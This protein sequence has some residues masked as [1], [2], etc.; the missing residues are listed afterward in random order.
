MERQDANAQAY[1]S[2]VT[3]KMLLS[4]DI[5]PPEWAMG[6]IWALENCTGLPGN[7]KWV[8]DGS[9]KQGYAFG[10]V[11]SP[12]SDAARRKKSRSVSSFPPASWGRSKD[13][14]SYFTST[15][16]V[17]EVG[18][19][20]SSMDSPAVTDDFESSSHDFPTRFESDFLSDKE[21]MPSNPKST[22]SLLDERAPPYT[23]RSPHGR[24]Q[25]QTY[26]AL[27]SSNPFLHS[28][29]RTGTN[30]FSSSPSPTPVENPYLT[31]RAA[32]ATPLQQ[33]QGVARAIALFD[34]NAVEVILPYC[35]R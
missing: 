9:G 10:G 7:R 21:S 5:S 3:A 20:Q 11:A 19:T 22:S 12:G 24:S 35:I 30:P 4:G 16:G 8:N 29:A 32:L 28:Q 6:L 18:Q 23:P 27:H 14:G 26:P 31:Q 25:S 2:D 13:T 17:D 34:F 33:R 15:P 1:H